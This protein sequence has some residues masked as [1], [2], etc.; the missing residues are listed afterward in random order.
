MTLPHL[1]ICPPHLRWIQPEALEAL[2]RKRNI[3]P[4]L[5]RALRRQ[6]AGKGGFDHTGRI[7][8]RFEPHK[9]P[10]SRWAEMRFAPRPG[11]KS[12]QASLKLSE[13]ERDRMFEWAVNTDLEAAY[14]AT[15][16]GA[17]QTMGFN[18]RHCGFPSAVAMVESMV[19][20]AP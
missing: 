18:H 12:W 16:W 13:A 5:L 8:M 3:E 9:M 19:Q 6:E 17:L 15:S 2:A 7:T 4:A 1:T 10:R 11:Q 20:G 14:A